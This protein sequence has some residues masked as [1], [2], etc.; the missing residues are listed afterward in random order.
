MDPRGALYKMYNV[1]DSVSGAEKKTRKTEGTQDLAALIRGLTSG[2]SQA[3]NAFLFDNL[4]LPAMVNFLAARAIT[5]DTDCCHKN[6]YLYRDSDGSG[7]WSAFPWDVDLSFGRVWTCNTPCLSY[8]DETI[9][10]NTALFVGN[11]NTV[12]SAVLTHPAT[13]TMYLRRFRSL[14]DEL[15]QPPGTPADQDRWRR[16][17]TEL[18][19]L[20]APDAA[21]D[22]ARWGTW[23]R[24]E[25][26]TQAVDRIHREFLPGRRNYLFS[27]LARAGTVPATQP[28]NTTV[29]FARVEPRPASGNRFH[30]F[31][32]ITNANAFAVDLSDWRIDGPVRFRFKPGTVLPARSNAVVSP[33]RRQF[34]SRTTG[35]RGGQ[36]LLV[37]GDYSGELDARGGELTLSDAKGRVVHSTQLPATPSAP[38]NQL[39]ITELLA[40]PA[41]SEDAADA[42][43]VELRNLGPTTLDLAG[44]R[45]TEGIRFDF[46]TGAVRTLDPSRYVL[47]VRDL[48]AFR[49]RYGFGLPV[50]GVYQG[51]LDNAGESLRLEDPSGEPILDFDYSP[52]SQPLA[53][54]FGHS[55]VV[56]DASTPPERWSSSAAW[57]ASASAGGSPGA[58]EPPALAQPPVVIHEILAHTDPP[59][60]DA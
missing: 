46:S 15:T 2:T 8:F 41:G 37:L 31:L 60:L 34:R 32:E 42:E 24:R 5:G 49:L 7:E 44:V 20:I 43:F 45:F 54:R 57:T 58:D 12:F 10:T 55:L 53:D 1:A 36:N 50:A 52:A 56:A 28:T 25:T 48:A 47:V 38:Q 29:R 40:N 4:D 26:I 9:Y 23:G 14:M 59:L 16:R 6:Y 21:L 35:P 11:N 19:D 22:L 30:E 13:R 51:Q 33:D 18:R 3:R 17:S 39:R 27:T